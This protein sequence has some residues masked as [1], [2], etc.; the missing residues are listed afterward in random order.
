MASQRPPLPFE[1]QG[2]RDP[3]TMI[4][5]REL[6]SRRRS[7]YQDIAIVETLDF[8]R[9]LF[10]DG[11]IQSAEFDEHVYHEFLVHPAMLM[12]AKVRDVLVAGVGEGATLRE[13]F[14]HGDVRGVLAVDIDAELI[15]VARE[16]L[17]SWHQGYFDD[18]RVSLRI[19]DVNDTLDAIDLK[20]IDLAILDLTDPVDEHEIATLDYDFFPRLSRAL[21]PD[22][23]VVMQLGELDPQVADATATTVAALRAEFAWVEFGSV[24]IESFNSTWGYAFA[25]Q[26][27]RDFSPTQLNARIEAA[28][29]E[30]LRAYRADSHRDFWV[31][32]AG[33]FARATGLLEP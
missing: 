7:A 16:F 27:R 20:S 19:E 17:P 4:E 14:R 12:H 3:L 8:G 9:A 30:Q 2:P 28:G 31:N 13:I 18:P 23:L 11:L 25:S 33:S 1:A 22:G 26:H 5:M 6:I 15:E 29:L 21:R 10:L 32:A 24:R